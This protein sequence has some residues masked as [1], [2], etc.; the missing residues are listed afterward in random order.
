MLNLLAEKKT[1]QTKRCIEKT[2]QLG[3]IIRVNSAAEKLPNATTVSTAGQL[4]VRAF[5]RKNLFFVF[6]RLQGDVKCKSRKQSLSRL[7]LTLLL[8]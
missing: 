1:L 5:I 7:C 8:N 3:L 4:E 6:S 2:N